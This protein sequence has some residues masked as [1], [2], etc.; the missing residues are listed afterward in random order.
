MILLLLLV[1]SAI[2]A[3]TNLN[4][5]YL[6]IFMYSSIGISVFLTSIFLSRKIKS[7]GIINGSLFGLLVVL[8]MYSISGI[9]TGF[10]FSAIVGVYA[11]ISIM[12]GLIGGAIGVNI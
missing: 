3:Y 5:K 1:S 7:K 6:D 12:T 4:D 11:L 9:F 2:F 10:N 8:I